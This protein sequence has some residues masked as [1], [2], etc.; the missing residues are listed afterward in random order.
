MVIIMGKKL[1]HRIKN[2]VRGPEN[3]RRLESAGSLYKFARKLSQR[4]KTKDNNRHRSVSL[5]CGDGRTLK[6]FTADDHQQQQQQ[7][8]SMEVMPSMTASP[9]APAFLTKDGQNYS[10]TLSKESRLTRKKGSS[11][12]MDLS[13]AERRKSEREKRSFYDIYALFEGVEQQDLDAVKAILDSNSVDVNSLNAENLSPLDI[14]LM[15]NNIPM[16]KMLLLQG[17]RESPMFQ[18]GGCRTQKLDILV[19]ESGQRVVDLTA[20]VLNGASGNVNMSPTQLKENERQLSHWE[21]RHK[22]LKR[23]KAGYDHARPPE[24]PTQVTLSVASN[25]SL[26]ISFD[27]PLNHNGAVVTKYKVEWSSYE[28]FLPLTG[29]AIVDDLRHLEHE[30]RG[31]TKGCRYYG[32]VSAC[33][34]K[35]YGA[36]ALSSPPYAVPSSWRDVEGAVSRFEGK[37]QS[38]Q[39]LFDQ[40]KRSRPPEAAEVK[41]S[42]S[43]DSPLQKK[44]ISIKNLFLSAPKF[45]KTVKRGV[46]L[47]CLL[48]CE[49]KVLVTSEEQIP[50][51]EVDENF[52]GTSIQ[53]DL[54]WLM[55][56]ACTWED[57]KL[58]RQDMEKTSSAGTTFRTK[59]LQAIASLQNSLGMQDLGQ[60]FHRPIRA[61]N[62]SLLLTLVNTVRDTKFVALGSAKWVSLSKLARRQSLPSTDI[63]DA[64]NMLIATVPEM[65]LYR[66]VNEVPLPNGLYLGFLKIQV[67][68]ESVRILVPL[69][70]PN[71]LPSVKIRDCPNVSKEEWDYLQNMDSRS[72][73]PQPEFCTAIQKAAKK[74]FT[75]LGISME[76]AS[77]Y[78]LYDVEVIEVSPNVSLLVLLP[79][80]EQVCIA[81]GT[82]NQ[83][84]ERKDLVLLPVQVF[85]T[86]HVHT[87]QPDMFAKYAR[88]S[89][90]TE[91]DVMLAQQ[92]QR[93]AFSTQ[94]L[95]CAKEQLEISNH[96]QQN[97]D[98]LWKGTRWVM[99]LI[100]FA[101]RDKY[102]RPPVSAFPLLNPSTSSC[103]SSPQPGLPSS[104]S[105][106][107][108]SFS[109]QTRLQRGIRDNNNSSS[110][111]NDCDCNEISVGK[112]NRR[113]A[114]FFDPN[115]EPDDACDTTNGH[116][117]QG[118]GDGDSPTEDENHGS[119]IGSSNS[120]HTPAAPPMTS[121]ILRVYAAYDTG[122]SKGVSVKLH[123]TAQTTARDV[124]NLVVR[125]L[126]MAALNKGKEGPIYSDEDLQNFCLVAVIGSRERVLGDEYP[127]LR[128]QNPWLK[129]RLY[130]RKVNSVLAA[131]QQGQAT[132][133]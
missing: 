107:S 5:D 102:L 113:I 78:R 100:T 123:I 133:V 10:P 56:I 86:I 131:I 115:D 66:D 55:K 29:E 7:L 39:V 35:G 28:D 24:L 68:V 32:R 25:S 21:F 129:G 104:S 87:Y 103:S 76:T 47:A 122:L 126:N 34:V 105:S 27:E 112:D 74:L 61:A 118:G 45:Q 97:L 93:E 42:G 48:V 70:T 109:Y 31:L 75:H 91:M 54:Y 50:I 128:L 80:V 20:V 120:S 43:T 132:A 14:A 106:S 62:G 73:S 12:D 3:E 121:G 2:M 84:A 46:H 51:V 111:Q 9:S 71:C 8:E 69:K 101:R 19:S 85:E 22:L 88:M 53:S 13:K 95:S 40:V 58:L 82:S 110:A 117:T 4:D 130:V 26:H 11:N 67:S 116:F 90:I 37:L 64:H 92:T 1:L 89:A 44:R 63:G 30:M 49:D 114:K 125:H 127:P 72:S 119:G 65:L 79:P 99:D 81:P 60:F 83:L 33:N 57:V 94:E 59:L 17:A 18:H 41:D 77:G 96:L 6:I 124:I 23:M 98:K 108:S 16:A 52:S 36:Y 15:T 38:L